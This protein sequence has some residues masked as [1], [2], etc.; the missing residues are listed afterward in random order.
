MLDL[1][2]EEHLDPT[3]EITLEVVK[4][5]AVRGVAVLTGRTFLLNILS[6]VAVGFLTVFL[7]PSDFG[8]FWIVSAI[9]NF[10]AYFSDVGLAAALIQKK[11]KVI[12]ADLNTTFFIQQVL[13]L[14]LLTVLFLTTPFL[15]TYYSFSNEAKLLLFA[16]GFSLLLSSLKTIPSVFL[17]PSDLSA[18]LDISKDG[19][20]GLR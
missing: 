1:T 6:L 16:L 5:R 17:D 12:K 18:F 7:D 3:A 20:H 8:I 11:E 15:Q 9:V 13:V 14:L 19:N 2:G 10:L 4:A